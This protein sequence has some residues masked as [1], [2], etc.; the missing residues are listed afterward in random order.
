MMTRRAK[1]GRDEVKMTFWVPKPL[2]R[3]VRLRALRDEVP[4]RILFIRALTA[5]L[6]RKED[7]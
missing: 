2:V 5:Y 6:A 3:A 7:R 1:R 4:L